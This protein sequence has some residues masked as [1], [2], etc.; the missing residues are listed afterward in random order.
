MAAVPFKGVLDKPKVKEFRG[1]LDGP[2][3]G[4]ST[5]TPQQSRE[6]MQAEV[7]AQAGEIEKET[8]WINRPDAGAESAKFTFPALASMLVP[9]SGLAALGIQSLFAGGGG[10]AGEFVKEKLRREPVDAGQIAKAGAMDA[11]GNAVA[12]AVVK[13][14]GAVAKK[15][16]SSQLDEPAKAAAQFARN[17]G[18]PFPLSSGAPGTPAARIQQGSRITLPGEIRNQMDANKVAQFLNNKVGT[19]T[20]A[21]SPVD[22]AAARGQQYLRQVFAPGETVYTETFSNLR[23]TIGDETAIPLEKTLPAMERVSQALKERGEMKAVYNRIRNILKASP[24]EQTA[25]QVDELY[26][27]LLKDAARNANA[28]KEA[29]VILNALA[30]DVDGIAKDFGVSF[31]DDLAKAKAVRDQFRELRNIPGLERLGKDFGEKGGTLGSR[32]WMSE[33]FAN[34]NGKAL[35]ELRARNPELYHDLADSW[36]ANNI[37]RFSKTSDSVIGKVLD[38][39]GLRSWYEQNAS[40]LKVIFGEPQARALDNFTNYARS[41]SGAVNQAKKGLPSPTDMLFRGGAEAAA[42]Y[43]NPLIAVPTEASAFVLARGLSDPSS[44]L[45]KVFTEGFSP[46]TRSFMVKSAGIAGQNLGED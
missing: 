36:L 25:Q 1:T 26:S 17:E 8:P 29:N 45:F 38:G 32:Q 27:G 11:A 16:F 33:L 7:A 46:A 9:G 2:S 14:L 31:T 3:I 37:N 6:S 39:P 34:P 12:G 41:M 5:M 13:G 10:A 35:A 22:D 43:T 4:P 15:V 23:K 19:I 44:Q 24:T 18:V 42:L 40:A 28:R 30:E 20:D 21:A